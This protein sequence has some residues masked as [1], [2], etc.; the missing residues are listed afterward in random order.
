MTDDITYCAA[1]CECWNCIRNRV[2]IRDPGRL[3][4]WM[5]AEDVPD[6]PLRDEKT[7]GE[8]E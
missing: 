6:C 5:R 8:T 1:E 7:D 2:N 4:S 3:H